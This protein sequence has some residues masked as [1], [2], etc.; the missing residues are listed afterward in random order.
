MQSNVARLGV[1][2][3]VI[4]VAVVLF[5]VLNGGDNSD[6]GKSDAGT[7]EVLDIKNG[8]PVG[9]VKTLTYNKGDTVTLQVNLDK[10]EEEIHV[11]G[12]ELEKPARTSPVR[13]SFPASIDGVFDIEVHLIGG[14]EAQIASL[15]VNP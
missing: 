10:P 1:L 5:I 11:H 14:G 13:L 3:G 8:E 12:Y 9:G 15:K 7:T 4:A 6:N 2:A